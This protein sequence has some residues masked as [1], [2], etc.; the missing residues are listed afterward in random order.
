MANIAS[1][2]IGSGLNVNDL[3]S[4]IM[5]LERRPITLIETKEVGTK[6]RITAYGSLKS[7]LASLQTAAKSLATPETFS[8]TKASVA[9]ASLLTAT[10]TSTAQAGSYTVEVKS[11]AKSQKLLSGAL[12]SPAEAL[13]HGSI[14][15]EFGTYS[16]GGFT[17]NPDKLT[18][19][20]DIPSGASSLTEVASAI[21][22]ARAGVVATVIHD[23]SAYFLSL[24]PADSGVA[25]SLRISVDDAVDGNDTD[26][27]GL[28]RLAY[29]NTTGGTKNMTEKVAASDAEIVIDSVTVKKPLNV[30]DDAIAGVTLNLLKAEI[31]TETTLS[32]VRDDAAISASVGNFVKAYNDTSKLLGELLAYNSATGVAGALQGEGTVRAIQAQVRGIM[33]QTVTGLPGGLSGLS[34]LGVTFQRDGTLLFEDYKLQTVLRNPQKDIE[35]LFRGSETSPGIATRMKSL[36]DSML[37]TDG[38]LSARTSG[39][40]DTITGY[41]TRKTELERRMARIEDRYRAQFTRLDVLVSNMNKTSSFLQQQLDNLPKIGSK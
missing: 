37:A 2:G 11:L 31:G 34:E 26:N 20:V 36:L 38:L 30:V 14:T 33:R 40:N 19:T 10:T 18:K 39:L 41:G 17:A 5:E 12:S 29:D 28:S 16:G 8:A 6:A 3:V 7:S 15:F 22:A 4:Q 32:I 27:A 9:N 13:G 35:A 23:G 25:N 24:S 1:P 21:N